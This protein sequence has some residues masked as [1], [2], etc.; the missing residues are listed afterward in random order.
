MAGF[1]VTVEM[2]KKGFRLAVNLKK[3][4]TYVATQ[5]ATEARKKAKAGRKLDGSQLPGQGGDD[6]K[7]LY[8][9][10]ALIN[11]IRKTERGKKGRK[12][13]VVGPEPGPHAGRETKALDRAVK[14]GKGVTRAA[15]RVAK[16]KG[17]SKESKL[18]N[19]QILGA[20]ASRTGDPDPLGFDTMYAAQLAR[21]LV[22]KWFKTK[23]KAGVD[24]KLK[25]DGRPERVRYYKGRRGI[26]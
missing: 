7:R 13:T 23:A 17:K 4:K 16:T 2:P 8:E 14:R 15:K 20:I 21:E 22:T 10:G 6:G 19:P 11:S 24:Y 26:R 3:M 9:T 12:R 25:A 18:G 1:K 5:I